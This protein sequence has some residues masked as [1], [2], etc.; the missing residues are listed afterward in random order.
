M[1]ACIGILQWKKLSLEWII[2]ETV[3]IKTENWWF[4][5]VILSSTLTLTLGQD[6]DRPIDNEQDEISVPSGK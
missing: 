1:F 4:N 6:T 3:F 2:L 5:N